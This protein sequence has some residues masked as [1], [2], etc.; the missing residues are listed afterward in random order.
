MSHGLVAPGLEVARHQDAAY[1]ED[2]HKREVKMAAPWQEPEPRHLRI[3]VERDVTC[4]MRDGCVLFSD[5][6]RPEGDG[7]W[8]V[9]LMRHPYDKTQAE[10]LTYAHPA[11]YARQGYMVVVQDTRGRWKSEGEWYPLLHE[12]QDGVDTVRWARGLPGSNGKVAMYGFS[13]AGATQLLSAVH[14]PEGLATILP[15]FTGSDYYD[16]WTYRGGALHHS[17]TQSWSTF[18]AIDTAHRMGDYELEGLTAGALANAKSLYWL[19]FLQ[20]PALSREGLAPYYA[21]WLR[22]ETYDDYW[23]RWSIRTRYDAID[24]PAL[25]IGGWYDIFLDG[26][27]ENF[28]GLRNVVRDSPAR[29]EQKLVIGPWLHMP[30]YQQVGAVDFGPDARNGLDALQVLWLDRHMKGEHN[31]LEDEPPVALFVMGANRWRFESEW[32]LA[33]AVPTRYFLRSKGRANSL[34]GNGRLAPEAPAEEPPDIFTYDPSNPVLSV[35]GR[36]C[37]IESL[38][39]MGAFDQRPQQYRNDV[40]VYTT[41]AL[42]EDTEVTGP[43][44]LVLYAESTAVDTDFSAV[45]SDVHPDGRSINVA[46]GFLRTR[47]RDS[48]EEPTPI[49][50]GRVY[51]YRLSLGATSN[52]FKAGHRIRLSVSS[53]SFPMFNRNDNS[54]LPLLEGGLASSFVATQTVLHDA[55]HPSHVV[56]SLVPH[57]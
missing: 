32:P 29:R 40:L 23:K 33:R 9:L 5:V 42:S 44:E 53:S 50:P 14:R 56:L 2:E 22:H 49:V 54:G 55:Q 7:P 45:L 3:R 17:F 18:L 48:L 43:V 35:G 12:E 11:W 38:T 8:P 10:N 39:P 4:R 51:K 24:V 41:E 27:L 31:Q 26:T 36:S 6:Y 34:N 13:Y 20:H 57:R 1:E 28:V 37:C 30:W 16:G 19:P 46:E 47:F 15:A 25:H 21:D 52:V